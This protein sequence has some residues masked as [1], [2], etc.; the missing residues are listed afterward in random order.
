MAA[1]ARLSFYEEEPAPGRTAV[2]TQVPLTPGTRDAQRVVGRCLAPVRSM[3]T[4]QCHTQKQRSLC[5]CVCALAVV[6]CLAR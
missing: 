5:S 4:R 1:C 3:H 6:A 2:G